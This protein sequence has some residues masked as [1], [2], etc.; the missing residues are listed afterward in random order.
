MENERGEGIFLT[1][2]GRN[3]RQQCLC[4]SMF[5]GQMRHRVDLYFRPRHLRLKYLRHKY[6]YLIPKYLYEYLYMRSKYLYLKPS[7]SVS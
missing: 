1:E 5:E 6:L 2:D 4:G 7:H 3:K